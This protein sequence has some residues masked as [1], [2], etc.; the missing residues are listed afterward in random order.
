MSM[1]NNLRKIASKHPHEIALSLHGKHVSYNQLITKID[2]A[3]NKCLHANIKPNDKVAIMLPNIIE[4]VVLFYALNDLSI[5]IVMLH[6]LS[7]STMIKKRC[8]LVG[9]SKIV[10]LDALLHRYETLNKDDLIVVSMSHSSRGLEKAYLT[11]RYGFLT[12][13]T[14]L[15]R[16]PSTLVSIENIKPIQDAVI[17]F[18]SGTTGEQ[19]AISLSNDALNALVVQLE[20]VID[21]IIGEDAMYCVLP[22]FHGFGLGITMHTVLSLGGR[23]VLV[24]RLKR[25]TLVKELLKEK[26]SYIA[27][28]P[29]LYRILL[30]DQTFNSSDLSFIKEAF[31]GG[32]LVAPQ[33]VETFNTLLKEQNSQGSLRIGYGMSE[34]TTAVSITNRF[35]ITPNCV[36]YPLEGNSF[37]VIK[38][39]GSI[40]KPYELGE[41]CITGPVLMNGY[42]NNKEL[43]RQVL[44]MHEDT[45]YYHS[46]DI[47][48]MD[49]QGQLFFSHRKDELMKVKGFFVN[50]LEI[51][52]ELYKVDGCMEVKVFVNKKETLCAMMVF[53][54]HTNK[55][56]MQEKTTKVL[57]HLDRWSIPKQYYVVKE[58]PKNEMRKYDIK[59]INQT[60]DQQEIEF[61]QEWS[62]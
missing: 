31:V 34:A 22:F 37:L 60:L 53:D 52:G 33:L 47:G 48:F 57:E 50:P 61:L 40:A 20:K 30:N 55:E 23:C 16:L 49:E 7:S 6:P 3:K 43:T 14:K 29:Y 41:I 19:K 2:E 58:I 32:E 42:Y 25:K 21:P 45:L 18:S 1:T 62:L 8:D 39:D 56:L 36:G 5:T 10:V 24:P 59:R 11:M 51:E 28:V 46:S 27:G 35:D 44:K 54:K 26:P 15:D 4:S 12:N 17:L 9:V 13:I 38:E